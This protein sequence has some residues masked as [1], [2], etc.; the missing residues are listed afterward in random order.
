MS[1]SFIHV[2]ACKRISFL[3]KA[4]LYSIVWA[5]HICFSIHPS[6]N[7]WVAS[8][9]WLLWKVLLW[10]WVCKYLFKT[11]LA[12]TLG[13]YPEIRLLAHITV[14]F[15]IL[16]G[17][18]TVFHSGCTILQSHQ[19]CTRFPISPHPY[20]HLLFSRLF[21]KKIVVILIGVWW[22]LTVVFI[23]ISL[24]ISD[25]E[26]VFKCFLAICISSL[27]IYLFKSFAHFLIW[28]FDFCCCW[29]VGILYIFWI[30]TPYWIYDL[31]IIL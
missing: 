3:F 30:L 25:V 26:H 4:E 2:V 28:L 31:Q 23:C 29:V 9:S 27:E 21:L 12:I 20:Q 19:Q 15:N 8:P 17:C 18:H 5:Y 16:R 14:L 22:Y 1:P 10:A 7:I 13:M 6:V 24:I 11:L